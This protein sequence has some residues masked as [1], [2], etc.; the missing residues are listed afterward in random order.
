MRDV[1]VLALVIAL[2]GV[3]AH[4]ADSAYPIRPVRLILGYPAGGAT[5]VAARLVAQKLAP[6]VG[7]SVVVDNRAG[8]SGMIA[9][10]MVAK[11]EQDGHT[12]AFA[13]AP[14]LAIYRALTRSPPYDS[15]R[16]FQPITLVARVPFML[17]VHPSVPASSVK[18]LV[19]L[20]KA[21]PGA[22]NFASFGNGTSNHLVGVAFCAATGVDIAHIPYK[23]SAPAIADLL[24]GQVQMTFDTV[25]ITL[26]QVKAG[27]LRALAFAAPRRSP[28]AAD[29]PTMDEAGVPKFVGGTWFGLLAPAR[30][31]APVVE[32]LYREVAAILRAPDVTQTFTERGFEPGGNSPA[33]FRAFIESET[34]R[35]LK[36]AQDAGVKPE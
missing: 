7:Q 6:A 1:R 30:T 5:D 26:P 8:A 28:L 11:A 9:A 29:V 32:R 3:T 13:A 36:V 19:A 20:A 31:P 17:V 10:A 14:E 15:L 21:K 27:K 22:L 2:W 24:G 18:E 35:W 33:E 25:P 12:L 23:G 16:D 4:A 34:R